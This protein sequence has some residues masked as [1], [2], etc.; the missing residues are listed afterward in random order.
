[1]TSTTIYEIMN[2]K[3]QMNDD[4]FPMNESTPDY[5]HD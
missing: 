5:T 3:R 1:M 2:E 4:V